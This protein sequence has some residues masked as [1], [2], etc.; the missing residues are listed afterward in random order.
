MW[1]LRLQKA[2][3]PV[4]VPDDV[5]AGPLEEAPVVILGPDVIVASEEQKAQPV[6]EGPYVVVE[7]WD[8]LV[9]PCRRCAKSFQRQEKM[10]SQLWG[11]CNVSRKVEK[12]GF[13]RDNR[14]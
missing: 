14:H 6:Q 8:G 5:T 4:T 7:L 3:D 13:L 9:S 10:C 11:P 1:Q 2:P 12:R